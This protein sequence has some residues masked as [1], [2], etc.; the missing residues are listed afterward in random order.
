MAYFESWI[1]ADTTGKSGTYEWAAAVWADSEL[2]EIAY[3]NYYV[4]FWGSFGYYWGGDPYGNVES[5]DIMDYAGVDTALSPFVGGN[6]LQTWEAYAGD[7]YPAYTLAQIMQYGTPREYVEFLFALDDELYGSAY[8]DKLNG[9][10]G[11]DFID[12]WR[13][14]DKLWGGPQNDTFYFGVG[15]NKDTIKDFNRHHDSIAIEA[16]NFKQIK[17]AAENYK[18]GVKIDF[19]SDELRIEGYKVKDLK[20]FDFDFV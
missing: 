4:D 14:N 13:G 8:N 17:K 11:D 19:G 3:A 12:G 7:M 9:W 15:Y 1:K 2:I 20:K 5:I 16:R 10:N 6:L 18:K